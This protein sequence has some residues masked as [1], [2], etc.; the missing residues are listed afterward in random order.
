MSYLVIMNNEGIKSRIIKT[1]LIFWKQLDF[2]QDENFKEWIE[3]G[4]EKLIN[5]LLKYQFVDPFKVWEHDGKIYCLDGKHRSLDL[6]KLITLGVDVPEQLP[7]TFMDCENMEEAAELVLVYSSAYASITKQGLFDFADKFNLELPG[8]DTLSLPGFDD[9]SLMEMFNPIDQDNLP[10][11]GK[12]SDDFLMVPFSILDSRSGEWMA[13]KRQWLGL[14]FNSQESRE[15]VE[16]IAKSGQSTQI[17]ELRNQMREI[18]KREPSWDEIIDKAKQKGMHVF[19][20]ASIFD[21]VLCELMY[22][23]F[24]VHKGKILDPFAG[25]SVRGVVAGMLEYNYWGIDLREDQVVANQKQAKVLN[26]D[27]KIAWLIGDSEKVLLSNELFTETDFIFSCPPY[28]YLEKYSD[29]PDDLSN[30]KY[31][32]FLVK[33]RNIISLSV[34]NLSDDSFACFVVA[35][36]R[37]KGDG[38]YKNFVSDTIA[39]FQD[40]GM[41][42][43][44]EMIFI[45]AIGSMAIRLKRQFNTGRKCGKIHQNILVFYKGNTKNIK[46]KFGELKLEIDLDKLLSQPN[47]GL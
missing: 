28:A 37:D 9:F 40:A 39:A 12:L 29:D 10:E 32:D 20:G 36:I 34:K 23:W 27:D 33:Y 18:L 3:N 35:D 7:A 45:N 17:Y 26:I 22:K 4:D 11:K 38:T 43:Y 41:K 19:E 5:S 13:R 25:G 24:C 15:D 6:Q 2:I 30:M 16:L 31:E 44:N 21:P 14:G 8:M 1:E 46:E 47:I 42:L